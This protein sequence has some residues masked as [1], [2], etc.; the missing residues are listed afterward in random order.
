MSIVLEFSELLVIKLCHDLAGSITSVSHSVDFLEAEDPA[1]NAKALDLL[2]SSSVEVMA[3][4]RY[5]RY[6]YGLS[7]QSGEADLDA[8]RSLIE[9][10]FASTKIRLIWR[11]DYTAGFITM[12]HQACKLMVN[13]LLLVA[14]T[15]IYGG[16]LKLNLTKLGR[17]KVIN[18]V[19]TSQRGVEIA[20]DMDPILF[21]HEDI[22]FKINNIQIHLLAKLAS[23]LGLQLTGAVAQDTCQLT[24]EGAALI[25]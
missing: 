5:Y 14:S 17:N 22:A 24:A 1:L 10:Y 20:P 2:K 6:A 15:M 19:G 11:Q 12:T 4:L 18:V 8:I 7:S 21:K 23:S 16:E 25:D 9:Q 13:M 3:K